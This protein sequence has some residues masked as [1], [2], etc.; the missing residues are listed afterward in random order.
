MLRRQRRGT[1]TD[2]LVVGLGNPGKQY[3]RTRHN[4]GAETVLVL[5]RR[6]GAHLRPLKAQ[7]TTDEVTIDGRRVA[8]G[9][10]LTYMN[11]SGVALR[12]L[13]DRY[14][15]EPDQIVVVHDELDLP[16]AVVR[17]KSG[18]GLAGHNGLR[19][20][21]QHLRT[22]DFLRVRIGIGK[23]PDP[24]RGANHVLDGFSRRDREEMDVAIEVA[25]D[26]VEA[27]VREGA[28]AAMTSFNA[29]S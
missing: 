17:V 27:I 1:P 8:F 22:R 11:E 4:V 26:A 24:R 18:G 13:V 25:A 19:S 7:A 23:P 16:P 12:R 21:E 3:E 29:R 28:A 5:A 2:L 15:V 6:H 9:I 10:P 20:I 14:D